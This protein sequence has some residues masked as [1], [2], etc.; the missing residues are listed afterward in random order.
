ML[1]NDK[2]TMRE[3]HAEAIKMDEAFI[4]YDCGLGLF[5]TKTTRII[6]YELHEKLRDNFDKFLIT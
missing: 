4:N 3:E 2:M 6:Y 5:F 1:K